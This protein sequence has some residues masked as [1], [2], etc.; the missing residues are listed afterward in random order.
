MLLQQLWPDRMMHLHE[1]AYCICGN[2]WSL[3]IGI[4][5]H[6][7]IACHFYKESSSR[8]VEAAN[9]LHSRVLGDLLDCRT[10]TYRSCMKKSDAWK[11]VWIIPK[12]YLFVEHIFTINCFTYDDVKIQMLI[13]F[14]AHSD[15]KV[16]IHLLTETQWRCQILWRE[17]KSREG[18]EE[19]TTA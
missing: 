8:R 7:W 3:Q 19:L 2:T 11:E 18:F 13:C 14:Q 6:D 15:T 16:E 9:A 1:T 4:I 5:P 17:R 10:N 12:A